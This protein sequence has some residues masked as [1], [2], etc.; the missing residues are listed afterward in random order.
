M[1]PFHYIALGGDDD[2]FIELG[3]AADFG[4]DK[5]DFTIDFWVY[6]NGM[7]TSLKY[8]LICEDSADRDARYTNLNLQV[9]GNKQK[10]IRPMFGVIMNDTYGQHPLKLGE[11]NH[12]VFSQKV[13]G[14][15]RA[16]Q[17]IYVNGE[18]QTIGKNKYIYSA[19]GTLL[20]G[21]WPRENSR[22]IGNIGPIRIWKQAVESTDDAIRL[23]KASVEETAGQESLTAF[24]VFDKNGQIYFNGF[25]PETEAALRLERDPSNYIEFDGSN[26][27]GIVLG[28]ARELGL[29]DS[30]FTVEAWIKP[31]DVSQQYAILASADDTHEERTNLHFLIRNSKPYMGF[32]DQDTVGEFVLEPN[33]WYH[34]AFVYDVD[35]EVQRVFVN[36][37]QVGEESNRP[38]FH[39]D[40]VIL[41][42]AWPDQNSVFKGK[43]GRVRFWNKPLSDSELQLFKDIDVYQAPGL[44]YFLKFDQAQNPNRVAGDGSFAGV[45]SGGA[46]EKQ[47]AEPAEEVKT[48]SAVETTPSKSVEEQGVEISTFIENARQSIEEVRNK[49]KGTGYNLG[50]VHL[51]FKVIPKEDG[52]SFIFPTIEQMHKTGSNLSTFRIDFEPPK[53]VEKPKKRLTNVPDVRDMTEIMARRQL[54]NAGLHTDIKYLVTDDDMKVDRIMLQDPEPSVVEAENDEGLVEVGTTVIIFIGKRIIGLDQTKKTKA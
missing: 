37:E 17:Y 14:N 23:M 45:Q 42:G 16:H 6:M 3:P 49:T 51:D 11:W 20:L 28:T 41:L 36:G 18:H 24:W 50:A 39:A 19:S 5:A 9:E 13:I 48:A 22:L 43:I 30:S 31:Y 46:T 25:P 12:L 38:S 4:V 7:D 15:G 8:P 26:K 47:R 34:L 1:Q 53:S 29:L 27:D 54:T 52:K 44:Q 32:Y 33:Q 21:H 35:W 10:G 40:D 2:P